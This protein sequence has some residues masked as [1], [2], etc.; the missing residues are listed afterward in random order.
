MGSPSFCSSFGFD[1]NSQSGGK[2]D[3]GLLDYADSSKSDSSEKSI[4]ERLMQQIEKG[5][6][7]LL[8]PEIKPGLVKLWIVP[9]KT[10]LKK[11]FGADS[12][13][14]IECESIMSHSDLEPKQ[15]LVSQLDILER[16]ALNLNMLWD[17]SRQPKIQNDVINK[18]FLGHGR[19]PVWSRI[20]AFIKDELGFSVE[21]F[22]S[23]SRVSSHII[24]ILSKFL[25]ECDAAVIVLAGD[26]YTSTGNV[27]ARQNVVHEIGLFQGRYGFDRVILF[28][29]A[30]IEEFSNVSG[31]QTVRYSSSPEEGFYELQ[32]ALMKFRPG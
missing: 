28:Q 10:Q 23:E 29:E 26:D 24:E 19:N 20:L 8:K 9:V 12:P 32:R 25:N 27:R 18:I 11:L 17:M 13:P 30:T 3:M 4:Y 15:S 22:E 21:A 1:L 7:I 14:V 5:R 2:Q 6:K 16:L 31:L